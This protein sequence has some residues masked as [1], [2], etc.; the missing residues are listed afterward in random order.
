MVVIG[1]LGL[2]GDIRFHEDILKTMF[3]K[4]DIK[5]GEIVIVKKSKDMENI[6][7]IIIPGGESTVIGVLTKKIGLFDDLKDKITNGLPTLGSCAGLIF[8]SNQVSDRI[9]KQVNQPILKVLNVTTERNT[10]GGQKES[11]EADVKISGFSDIPFKGVFIRAPTI[12]EVNSGVEILSRF[13]DK[14]IAVKQN[15]I[16]ALSFHPE[17][18]NDTRIHE[19]FLEMINKN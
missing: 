10:F 4:L 9:V 19:F 11:F 12:K 8:L 16:I 2:Q 13:D 18:S 17:L 6:D 7:G 5:D 3:H 14:I 1:I 15:N